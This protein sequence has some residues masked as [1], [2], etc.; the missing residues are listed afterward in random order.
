MDTCVINI[1]LA[2]ILV[3]TLT[4]FTSLLYFIDNTNST[5]NIV[6]MYVAIMD[7]MY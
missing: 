7:N 5:D 1:I 6:E 3:G 4:L 2:T